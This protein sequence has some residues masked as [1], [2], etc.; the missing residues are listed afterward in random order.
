MNIDEDKYSGLETDN[1]PGPQSSVEGYIVCV[2]GIF[3]E[4]IFPYN[5]KLNT[6]HKKKIYMIYLEHMA[7]SRICI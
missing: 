5:D 6:R 3:E 7:K 1:T 4:V 2:T